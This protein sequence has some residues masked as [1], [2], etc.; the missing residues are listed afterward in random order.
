LLHF[1]KNIPVAFFLSCYVSHAHAVLDAVIASAARTE[2]RVSSTAANITTI[3]RQD[4]ESS[5]AAHVVDVLRG[6]SGVLIE[7]TFGD[8]SRAVISMRGFSGSAAISNTLILID[9]RR[10]NNIDLSAPDLN[11]LS[12]KDVERIEIIQGGAGVLYG[13]Q[14]VGG[15]VNIITKKVRGKSGSLEASSGTYHSAGLRGAFGDDI[16]D[17]LHYGISAEVRQS[18]NYRRQNNEIDYSSLFAKSDYRHSKGTVYAELQRIDED[19]RTPGALIASDLL[20]DRRQTVVDFLGDFTKSETEVM[21]FGL[22]Q[23]LGSRWSLEAEATRRDVQREIRQSFRDFAILTSSTL[24]RK[25]TE[26]TPRFIGNIPIENGDIQITAG[27]DIINS[28]FESEITASADAQ[29]M[30]SEYIQMVYPVHQS[31]R[32]TAGFRHADVE[33]DITSATTNGKQRTDVNVAELGLTYVMSESIKLFGRL[34]QNFRFAK[35]DELTYV[36]PGVQLRPQ[37][38][39]SVE[40]GMKYSGEGA[41]YKIAAYHLAVIDEIDFDPSAPTPAGGFFAGANVNLSPTTHDG[42]TFDSRFE[43]SSKTDLSVNYT[44]TQATFDSGSLAGNAI[45][46]V[47]ENNANIVANYRFTDAA[48]LNIS[49]VFVGKRYV[50]GDNSNALKKLPSYTVLNS[51][52]M[53]RFKDWKLNLK[54]NNIMNRKYFE[55]ATN[56]GFTPTSLFPSPERNILLSAIWQFR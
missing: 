56:D 31:I 24:K 22:K 5:G 25:Q 18:D 53:Y 33:D 41:A 8:G 50:D 12:L 20:V 9:G 30:L 40:I 7:D 44:Y 51:N 39:E 4:I 35:V 27:I 2:Q 26:F 38:G 43:T 16:T 21:R 42:L 19:L 13:D 29:K 23:Q 28:D 34:D 36:S 32:L 14:A 45:P 48:N 54:I 49:A 3:T 46:G 15:V 10:L 55:S 52:L 6:Q 1:C 11:S 47:A 37:T 17:N